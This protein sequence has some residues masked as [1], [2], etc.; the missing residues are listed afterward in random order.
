M[1]DR[2]LTRDDGPRLLGTKQRL[3]GAT[4]VVNDAT[5]YDLSVTGE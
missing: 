5:K 3:F 2:Y 4:G 1:G